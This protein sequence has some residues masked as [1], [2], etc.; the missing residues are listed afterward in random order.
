MTG[1]N[2]SVTATN[3]LATALHEVAGATKKTPAVFE[4]EGET[5]DFLCVGALQDAAKEPQ[6]SSAQEVG[7]KLRDTP[8]E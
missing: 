5:S 1:R 2:D 6:M 8:L 3:C 4:S 7:P